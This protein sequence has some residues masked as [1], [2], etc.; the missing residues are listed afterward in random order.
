MARRRYCHANLSARIVFNQLHHMATPSNRGHPEPLPCLYRWRATRRTR[1]AS[2]PWNAR[3]RDGRTG[4]RERSSG[5]RPGTPGNRDQAPSRLMADELACRRYTVKPIK[6]AILKQDEKRVFGCT[7]LVVR[8]YYS[9]YPT[10]S[11]SP[12]RSVARPRH[13]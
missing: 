11:S 12:P 8:A 2:R 7:M 6:S 10:G 3:C 4:R 5:S 1:P 13:T 9:K